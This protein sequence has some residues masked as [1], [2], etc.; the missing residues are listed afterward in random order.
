M[1][2]GSTRVWNKELEIGQQ[3]GAVALATFLLLLLSVYLLNSSLAADCLF[4]R[5]LFNTSFRFTK[6]VS[7]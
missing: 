5:L 7:R 6:I 1:H 2:L 4:I 3:Q